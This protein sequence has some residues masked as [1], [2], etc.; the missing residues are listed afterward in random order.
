MVEIDGSQGEGGG[1]MLRTALSLS[2]I[3]GKGF[4]ISRIRKGREKP[5]LMRQHLVAVQAAAAIAGAELAGDQLGS[6]ELTF[7]P[8]RPA[9]GDYRFDIGTAGSTSLVLQTLIPPLLHAGGRSRLT[10]TGGTHVP[11]SPSWH[12]LAEVFAPTV[13]RLGVRLELELESC[14]FYP[15]GGGRVLCQ[16]EPAPRLAAFQ[17]RERGRLLKISG[18][19]AVG[20]LPRS[21]AERQWRSAKE[22]LRE[23]VGS[24][25]PMEVEV[26]E[27]KIYGQ[28]TFIFLK[29]EYERAVTGF[30]A[31]GA[32]GKPAELVGEEA[33]RELIAQH[34]SGE[35]IDPHLADQLVLYL[36]Q[37]DGPSVLATSRITGHL[38]TNLTVT[39]QFLDI[40]VRIDGERDGPGTVTIT[41]ASVR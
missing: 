12:Y 15:K 26:R 17:A 36:A 3:S 40:G 34:A 1:Q 24:D 7:V 5:G 38:E 22:H 35:P 37:A 4:R 14:G 2:C 28:G 16:V 13:A 19:S 41:P 8:R 6:Q 30:T 21:I 39:S 32:R 9:A 33:A 20:N 23:A 18:C 31:L 27:F 25:L 11:F 29:A 10:L